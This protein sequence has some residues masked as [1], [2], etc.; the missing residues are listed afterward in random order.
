MK[1]L[2]NCT[3]REF[4]KQTS[5][6]KRSVEKWL[7]VT[8]IMSIRKRMPAEL[9]EINE[10]T[11]VSEQGELVAKRAEMLREQAYKNV[12]LILDEML[13]KHP[14]ETL[15]VLAYCCFVEP[16]KVDDHPMGYY[17]ASINEM[18]TDESVKAFFTTL[19]SL[20]Q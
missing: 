15:E 18:L 3:P 20:V 4:L 19:M 17:L 10:N 1:N 14:D 13:E 2:A 9:P 12:S 7:K 8:D 16:E 11:P 6:I 5:R